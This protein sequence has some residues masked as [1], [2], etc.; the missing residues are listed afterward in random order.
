[1]VTKGYRKGVYERVTKGIRGGLGLFL[2]RIG[3]G[4]TRGGGGGPR[5]S[6]RNDGNDTSVNLRAEGM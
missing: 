3:V 4:T 6:R 2:K 1:M 5:H